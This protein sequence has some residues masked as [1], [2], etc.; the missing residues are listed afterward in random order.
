[1]LP[2]TELTRSWHSWP[3]MS[4]FWVVEVAE[5]RAADDADAEDFGESEKAEE[6][7][8]C[9]LVSRGEYKLGRRGSCESSR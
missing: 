4:E 9:G 5:M 6:S 2:V 1:M 3:S 7:R 8:G